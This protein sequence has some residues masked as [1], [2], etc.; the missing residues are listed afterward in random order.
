MT[1]QATIQGGKTRRAL[2][3]LAALAAGA[4]LCRPAAAQTAAEKKQK[5]LDEINQQLED[6][7]KEMEQLRQ[8]EDRIADE[9][10]GLKKEES[11]NAARRRELE[12]QL[13]GARSRS[14]D[15]RLKYDSL[16]KTRKDLS[17]DIHGELVMLS[18]QKDFY[19][20]YFGIR[21]I[22]KDM[23][24]RSAMLNK[25]ALLTKIKGESDRVHKDIE[26]FTR[27]GG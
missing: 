17:G 13:S 5:S 11:R 12:D 26:V 8:E 19:Y 3:L 22:T 27:R 1:G 24:M 20:P 23:L 9:L 7:K 14:S 16:E 21:D 10:S 18:L 6:K 15:A 25:R 4:A 2:L